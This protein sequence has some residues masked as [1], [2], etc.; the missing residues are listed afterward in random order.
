MDYLPHR[1]T[2]REGEEE[3]RTR[4]ERKIHGPKS[5]KEVS[6]ILTRA[7]VDEVLKS[8]TVVKVAIQ[9]CKI[10]L[11]LKLASSKSCFS[12]YKSWSD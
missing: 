2:K 7:V 4:R 9:H 6:E 12:T 3:S 8:F 5:S 11:K 1:H 10:T